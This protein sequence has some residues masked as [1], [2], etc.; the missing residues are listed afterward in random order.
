MNPG[1]TRLLPIR[2]AASRRAAEDCVLQISSSG[3]YSRMEGMFSSASRGLAARF[4]SVIGATRGCFMRRLLLAGTFL[5]CMPVLAG[6]IWA[7]DFKHETD[8]VRERQKSEI[9]ALKLKHKF[10]KEAMKGQTV[11][12]ALRIQME[13]E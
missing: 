10:T 6:T 12:K 1:S 4:W 5:V 11:S 7:Q 13:N 8:L 9:K 2:S 3:I